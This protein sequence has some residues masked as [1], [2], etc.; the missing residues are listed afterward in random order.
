[1]PDSVVTIPYQ[2]AV[3]NG[4][5]IKGNIP[6]LD[7]QYGNVWTNID[8]SLFKQLNVQFGDSI[9]VSIYHK[10]K[11]MYKGKMPYTE[12]FGAV[13]TGKPLAYL[14]SLLQLS[15]ALNMA[16]FASAYHVASGNEWSV[17]VKK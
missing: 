3:L 5:V 10:G 9:Q 17:E 14:N 16:N 11:R 4:N 2:K 7:I 15:F 12:T 13:K 6:I 1:L 8:A